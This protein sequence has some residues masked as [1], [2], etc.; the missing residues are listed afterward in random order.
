MNKLVELRH[1]LHRHPELAGHEQRTSETITRSLRSYGPDK[2]VTGLG[3]CGL[4]ATLEGHREGPRVLVR[5]ELDALPIPESMDISHRSEVNG[6]SH[7][8]GHDGHMAML[9]GLAKHIHNHPL[10]RGS[11]TL[12]FQ[13]AEETGEGAARVI[14][15]PSFGELRPDF[16][17]AIHNL[18]GFDLGTVVVR[19]G[20]FASASVGL[21]IVLQGKT[22]HAAEPELGNSPALAVAQLIQSLSSAPQFTSALHETGQVTVIHARVGEVAFGTSP[23]FGTV[24]ATI[25]SHSRDVL[26]RLREK[27]TA[28]AR[29]TAATFGLDVTVDALEP[30]PVTENDPEVVKIITMA[31]G[32]IGADVHQKEFPFAWSEDFGHFTAAYPGALIGLGAGKDQP[33]LHHPDYDFPDDLLEPGV[34]LLGEIVHRLTESSNV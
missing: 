26:E 9:V 14:G 17:L 34:E 29:G 12:L 4:A 16:V 20:V 19:S 1:L 6:A 13:P 25:R 2:L 5:C 21:R 31:A 18:P 23:G 7:K 8:C 11:V 15:D 24:M 22:S 10:R 28:L 30:F 3:G 33:P 27:C 32:A